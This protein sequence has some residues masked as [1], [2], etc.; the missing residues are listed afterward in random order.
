MTPTLVT[1][2][3]VKN[4]NL[5][6][7]KLLDL[8]GN[9]YVN[10][11][12]KVYKT[13]RNI[14][15]K[16]VPLSEK[17]T[18]VAAA[19]RADQNTLLYL[20][21]SPRLI[22]YREGVITSMST[23]DDTWKQGIDIQTYGRYAYVL[24]PVENQIW[25]YERRRSNYSAAAAYNNGADLSR[26]IS[27]SIDGAIYI[28]S[29]DGQIKKLFR[30]TQVDYDFRDLPSREF[31]GKNLKL[32]TSANLE[33]LYILDPDNQRVLVFVKGDRYATYKKQIMYDLPDARDF[34]VDDS[35]QKV[36]LLTKDKIYTF[37]L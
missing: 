23:A 30:G 2:L 19:A 36:H 34:I 20:T 35:G 32:Y 26:S 27:F 3:S 7:Q 31:M 17:E 16:G 25:K 10:D 22:E 24:D 5:E 9:L 15:E 6:A 11:D 21:A 29:D 8:R 12:K 18:V 13:I 14:V 33:F 28:L 4:D 37:S 1:D